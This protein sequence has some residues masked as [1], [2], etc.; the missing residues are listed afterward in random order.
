V[1]VFSKNRCPLSVCAWDPLKQPYVCYGKLGTPKCGNNG[2]N[3]ENCETYK[4]AVYK[5]PRKEIRRIMGL[6]V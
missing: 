2:K 4:N 1:N 6:S 3:Y 5:I